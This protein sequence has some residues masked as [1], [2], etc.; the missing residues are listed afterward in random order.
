MDRY[1]QGFKKLDN[2]HYLIMDMFE[3]HSKKDNDLELWSSTEIWKKLDREYNLSKDV[4]VSKIGRAMTFL[5]FQQKTVLRPRDKKR[6]RFWYLKR[7]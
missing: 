4:T 5:G 3:P 6:G 1:Q 2:E 7:V